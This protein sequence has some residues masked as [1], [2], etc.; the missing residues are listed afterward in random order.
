MTDGGET[1]AYYR[2]PHT[3]CLRWAESLHFLLQDREGVELF[4]KYA[5]S[6]GGADADRVKFFFACEGLKQQIDPSKVKQ[7][8]GAIYKYF[9]IQLYY[10]L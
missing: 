8:V 6:Q 1:T 2:E 9:I 10:M 4:K 5:D 7:I 3:A